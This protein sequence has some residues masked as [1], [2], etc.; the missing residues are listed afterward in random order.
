MLRNGDYE[1]KKVQR[2]LRLIFLPPALIMARSCG[3]VRVAQGHS[4]EA[5]GGGGK[6]RKDKLANPTLDNYSMYL[7]LLLTISECY[8]GRND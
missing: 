7:S 3:F 6:Q 2:N 8:Y 5:G 4:G 1:N